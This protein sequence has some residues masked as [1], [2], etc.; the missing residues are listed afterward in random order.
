MPSGVRVRVPPWTP[1]PHRLVAGR[2]PFKSVARVRSPLGV[3]CT[4][5]A[6]CGIEKVGPS[7]RDTCSHRLVA[8]HLILS[9]AARVRSSLG[10]RGHGFGRCPVTM[11]SWRNWNTRRSQKPVPSGM[12]V[13]PPPRPRREAHPFGVGGSTAR[14][15]AVS[16]QAQPLSQ[17]TDLLRQGLLHGLAGRRG[18]RKSG[19][20]T[21]RGAAVARSLWERDVAGSIPAAPTRWTRPTPG[22]VGPCRHP[23]TPRV[24]HLRDMGKPGIPSASGAEER[25]FDSCYPDE[26]MS[27]ATAGVPTA[28]RTPAAF[29]QGCPQGV[30]AVAA[31]TLAAPAGRR[32]PAR[33]A[34]YPRGADGSAPRSHR[35]GR[36]FDSCR[37]YVR[38]FA[39]ES[40]GPT[41][42]RSLTRLRCV[43]PRCP[44]GRGGFAGSPS[45]ERGGCV[46]RPAT[47]GQSPVV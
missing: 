17:G 30:P 3:P 26:G 16:R 43:P 28:A 20:P 35:G 27:P 40:T 7:I 4:F 31:G 22:Y 41:S 34:A 12:R 19:P 8:G 25:R 6:A 44:T 11:A 46:L 24:H 37:G 2:W 14:L 47:V 36:R 38:R 10:V 42:G 29:P 9:Q 45:P 1:C 13:R 15:R 21:G 5:V 39:G 18:P 23:R 33:P 32:S